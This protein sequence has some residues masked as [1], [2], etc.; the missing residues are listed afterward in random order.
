MLIVKS[1]DGGNTFSSPVKV[2]NFY[3]LPDCFTYTGE[4]AFRACVPTAPAT[5][6]SV[7]RAENYPSGAALSD[8]RIVVD[9][10]SY[11][12]PHS[13]ETLGNCSPNGLSAL[14]GLNKFSGVG[15]VNGCNN[16]ILRSVSVNGGASF[17]GTKTDPR[18][19]PAISNEGTQLADQWWQWTAKAPNGKAVT[20]YY[21]RQYGTDMATGAM[22]VTLFN[23][24]STHIRVT[25]A[26]MPAGNDFPGVHGFSTFFGDYS[27]IAVGS[28]GVAHPVWMDNRN[29]LFSFDPSADPR[30]LFKV[31]FQADIYTASIKL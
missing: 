5:H 8:T 16:D 9:F 26:S 29:P 15:V 11:I 13:N 20:S 3:D 23:G 27:G 14:T 6:R 24:S 30:V 7:F 31:G 10:G 28:D 18:E 22:D 21:D 17:T 12:N 19:L 1:T 2:T 4:S 25:D